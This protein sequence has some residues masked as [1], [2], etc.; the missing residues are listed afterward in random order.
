M[1]P[2][3]TAWWRHLVLLTFDAPDTAVAPLVPPGCEPDRW[4]DRLQVSLVALRMD[5]VRVGGVPVPGFTSFPQ[6]N[7]RTYLR[8]AGQPGVVFVREIVPSRLVA[9]IARWR[10]GEP[11]VSG[12]VESRAGRDAGRLSVEYFFGIGAARGRVAVRAEVETVVPDAGSFEFWVTQRVRSCRTGPDGRLRSF[13]VAH[14]PWA[15]HPIESTDVAV[16]FAGLY[17]REWSWLGT[18][19][20]RSVVLAAGSDVTVSTPV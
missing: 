9:A 11:F 8:H 15:V 3:L 13:A 19:R 18:A 16:D 6:V 17:G 12:R 10:F 1:A 20:P 14:P 2:F 7:V 4:D 5:R